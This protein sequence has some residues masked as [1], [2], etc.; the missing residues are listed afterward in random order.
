MRSTVEGWNL[1][2]DVAPKA[3]AGTIAKARRLRRQMSHPEVILWYW[4][5]KRPNG[6]KFR[7][8]HPSGPYILD[9]FCS[10]AR[11]AIEVDGEGHSCGDRSERDSI[12]D[13]WFGAAG[14]HTLRIAAKD[15]LDDGDA[16]LRWIIAE[17]LARLPLH[18]PAAPAGP[19]PRGKLGED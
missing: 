9:F 3:R 11:L 14:I 12:R 17:A 13:G 2:R 5:R 10:D 16:V 1:L 19:R 4:L 7:R 18:H 6:L 8:Q 15:I